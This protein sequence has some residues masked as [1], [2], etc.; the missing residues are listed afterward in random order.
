MMRTDMSPRDQDSTSPK[1]NQSGL[2][3]KARELFQ[4]RLDKIPSEKKEAML[5]KFTEIL[6][7]QIETAQTKSNKKLIEKLKIMLTMVEDEVA[8]LEDTS[9][10]DGLLANN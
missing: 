10:I 3:V 5:T 7:K 9:L 8:S 6:K 2:S 4:A 1:N